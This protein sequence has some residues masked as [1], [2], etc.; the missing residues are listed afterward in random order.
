MRA[1]ARSRLTLV[2]V[3]PGL[4]VQQLQERALSFAAG[5][6][7]PFGTDR[8]ELWSIL[9]TGFAR[10]ESLQT[11]NH[12]EPE[13]G[14][15]RPRALLGTHASCFSL[16]RPLPLPP[17]WG[18]RREMMGIPRTAELLNCTLL[19]QERENYP[20][21]NNLVKIGTVP[22]KT[23]PLLHHASSQH[24]HASREAILKGSANKNARAPQVNKT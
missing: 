5:A 9:F 8:D 20:L 3:T 12:T 4:Y 11:W 21:V 1:G 15:A 24:F 16:S 19:S 18:T 23:C 17:S 2:S 10:E 13:L 7:Q 22:P 14:G 6:Q